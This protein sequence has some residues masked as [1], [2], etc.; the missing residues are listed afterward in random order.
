MGADTLAAKPNANRAV[1]L[2]LPKNKLDIKINFR[3]FKLFKLLAFEADKLGIS[4]R[5]KSVKVPILPKGF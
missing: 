5:N 1:L 2:E 3:P 4:R